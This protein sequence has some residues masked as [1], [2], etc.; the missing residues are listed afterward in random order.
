MRIDEFSALPDSSISST[1]QTRFMLFGF[2][3]TLTTIVSQFNRISSNSMTKYNCF[4]GSA[5]KYNKFIGTMR[6]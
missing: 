2:D 1:D 6:G 3:I 4:N 5:I